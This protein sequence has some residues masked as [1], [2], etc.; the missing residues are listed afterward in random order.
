MCALCLRNKTNCSKIEDRLKIK[1]N[2][3]A[4]VQYAVA[5]ATDGQILQQV[6]AD[7]AQEFL[8]G[9]QL[10]LE[11]FEQNLQGLS[12]GDEFYFQATEA[13]AYGPIDSKA[14]VNL[15]LTTF[16][17]EDGRIDDEVVRIGHVFPMGDKQ[18]NELLGKIVALENDQVTM[19]FNHPMAGKD[20][21]FSGKIVAV[22][23]ALPDEIPD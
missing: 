11:V 2:T 5:D 20:L 17:E 18:G 7:D 9:N 6:T 14:I 15:P 16:A 22:R 1:K 23:D 12:A 3:I 19:D 21:I 4:K 13:E 10:L 8:F